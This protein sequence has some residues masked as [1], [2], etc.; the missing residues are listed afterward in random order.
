MASK[1]K[2]IIGGAILLLAIG[3]S[4]C[5]KYNYIDGGLAHG[6]HD[7][8]MWEYFERQST[9]WDSTRIMIEHAGMKSVF[10]G[11]GSHEQITFFGLTDIVIV[12]YMLENNR[13][14]DED[15]ASGE[16]VNEEDYWY[17]V[18]DI[19]R[20]TCIALLNSLIVPQRL[21][22]KDV[23]RGWRTRSNDDEGEKYVEKEGKVCPTLSGELFV[24]MEPEDYAGIQDAGLKTLWIAK[25]NNGASNWRVASTDIQTNNGV[26]Q[27]MG[28]DFNIINFK[29]DEQ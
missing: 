9:D 25:R 2:K 10:D 8:S 27:S 24:W 21:M 7:C 13:L 22:L 17:K 4:S 1:I 18:T 6:I 16:E 23:P 3:F 12:R 5:T 29:N 15:K 14:L 19:P 26:V 11:S 20:E 28:Y